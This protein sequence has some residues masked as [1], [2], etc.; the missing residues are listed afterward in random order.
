MTIRKSLS[1]LVNSAIM[2]VITIALM[3]TV[4]FSQE[5]IEEIVVTARKKEE[6]LQSIPLAVSAVT[7]AQIE[8]QQMH[9]IFDIYPIPKLLVG[10]Q[11][12]QL[13]EDYQTY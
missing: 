2:V 1:F 4:T 9:S 11:K 5:G 7:A 10:I 13:F 12:D 6:T 3:P 8:A